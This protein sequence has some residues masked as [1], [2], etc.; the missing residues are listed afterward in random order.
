MAAS[1]FGRSGLS[2][3]WGDEDL[4]ADLDL[5]LHDFQP[6]D[7]APV[8]LA[9]RV[10]QHSGHPAA[11]VAKASLFSATCQHPT[12]E[13]AVACRVV[14]M[15]LDP[16]NQEARL[17]L[18]VYEGRVLTL[19]AWGRPEFDE[20]PD[21]RWA[22][23]LQQLTRCQE[24][25]PV[26]DL[27][28]PG[29]DDVSELLEEIG[30]RDDEDGLIAQVILAQRITMASNAMA[31]A[32][33][34]ALE[35]RSLYP[36]PEWFPPVARRFRALSKA[37]EGLAIVIGEEQAAIHSRY[38]LSA[39]DAFEAYSEALET[40]DDEA[41]ERAR[42]ARRDTCGRCHNAASI[43]GPTFF[44]A[45]D[46]FVEGLDLPRGSVHLEFDIAPAL[47]DGGEWSGRLAAAFRAALVLANELP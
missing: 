3:A 44:D 1:V 27:S 39:A 35:A 43:D 10:S 18:A 37:S 26:R 42:I 6:F 34:R 21:L 17:V 24:A 45:F 19:G 8:E 12:L 29:F 5:G 32:A 25:G 15:P 13:K 2:S 36:S 23:Y 11:L 38:A 14:R 40:T 28:V 20:D 16:K 47:G 22:M 33:R 46:P 30:E 7:A 4:A 41:I 9:E 31:G